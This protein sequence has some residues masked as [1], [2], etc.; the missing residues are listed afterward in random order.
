MPKIGDIVLFSSDA[1]GV[2]IDRPAVIT[3][4]WSE[5]T[6][7]LFVFPDGTYDFNDPIASTQTSVTRGTLL[8]QWR[9]RE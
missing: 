4:V 2:R 1:N 3:H 5:Q 7:N 9:P 6:V 8:N